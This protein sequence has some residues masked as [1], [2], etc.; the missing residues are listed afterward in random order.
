M[1]G[2]LN[3]NLEGTSLHQHSFLRFFNNDVLILVVGTG[4]IRQWFLEIEDG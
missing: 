4:E 3:K 2:E 1:D